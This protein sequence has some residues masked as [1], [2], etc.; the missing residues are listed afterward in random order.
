L[1]SVLVRFNHIARIVKAR[2]TGEQKKAEQAASK[3]ARRV[4]NHGGIES[5]TAPC[6][7]TRAGIVDGILAE[8]LHP[9]IKCDCSAIL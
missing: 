3:V 4:R 7:V 2:I 1:N 5:H 6:A 9:P 8:I